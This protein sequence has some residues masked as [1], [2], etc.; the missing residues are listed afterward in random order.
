[1]KWFLMKKH[2]PKQSMT[3]DEIKFDG[4]IYPHWLDE[5][6]VWITSKS[7]GMYFYGCEMIQLD[8]FCAKRLINDWMKFH[9]ISK[10]KTLHA[11]NITYSLFHPWNNSFKVCLSNII[12]LNYMMEHP[13][14]IIHVFEWINLHSYFCGWNFI[15]FRIKWN[16]LR[17]YHL[18]YYFIHKIYFIHRFVTFSKIQPYLLDE[19]QW[20]NICEFSMDKL[21]WMDHISWTFK[22]N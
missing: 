2:D 3:L 6:N 4:W 19:Y 13:W 15:T 9:V 10:W 22:M 20:N 14:N 1:M 11:W 12:H 7:N 17:K 18:H 5:F 21:G 8:E 16:S